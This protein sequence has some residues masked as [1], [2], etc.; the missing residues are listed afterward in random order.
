MHHHVQI[1]DP[2]IDASGC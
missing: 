2:A 1:T